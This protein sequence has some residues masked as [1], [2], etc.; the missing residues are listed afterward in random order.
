MVGG[1]C[2]LHTAPAVILLGDGGAAG[3][4]TPRGNAGRLTGD[5]MRP[6][7]LAFWLGD[8]IEAFHS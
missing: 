3:H 1:A 8:T 5:L 6:A 4:G 2:G 7:A